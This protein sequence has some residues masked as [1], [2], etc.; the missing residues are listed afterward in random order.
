MDV[1][2]KTAL[3]QSWN[4]YKHKDDSLVYV[5]KQKFRTVLCFFRWCEWECFLWIF[6]CVTVCIFFFN[7]S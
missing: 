7:K 5:C 3:P 6:S 2:E 1:R 4:N